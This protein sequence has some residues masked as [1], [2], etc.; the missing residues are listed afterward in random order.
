MVFQMHGETFDI[1]RGAELVCRGERVAHQGLCW[2]SALGFQ[3]HLELTQEMIADWIRGRG[4]D[5]QKQILEEAGRILRR[6][7]TLQQNCGEVLIC[8]TEG[9]SLTAAVVFIH[10]LDTQVKDWCR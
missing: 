6:A 1:P 4:A 9:V 2:G 10:H 5:E 8:P 3:F 7:I